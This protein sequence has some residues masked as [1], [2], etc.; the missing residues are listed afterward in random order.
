MSA[1]TDKKKPVLNNRTKLLAGIA[2]VVVLASAP[3]WAPIDDSGTLKQ[4]ATSDREQAAL[5]NTQADEA[6]AVSVDVTGFDARR[7]TM[8]I[9]VPEGPDLAGLIDSI[10][11]TAARAGLE[12]TTASPSR[13]TSEGTAYQTFSVSITVTGDKSRLANFFDE[14]RKLPRYV[15]VETVSY[16]QIEGSSVSVVASIRF[17]SLQPDDVVEAEADASGATTPAE[18]TP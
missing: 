4:A 1:K 16:Q 17:Y 7:N 15:T 14:L 2:A 10:G 13:T 8:A 11:A 5:L 3:S 18:V 9:A 12:W 6:E